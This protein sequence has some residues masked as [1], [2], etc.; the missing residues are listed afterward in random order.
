M[1][2]GPQDRPGAGPLAGRRIVVTRPVEQAMSLIRSLE[3]LGAEVVQLP[4]IAVA[5]VR[6]LAPLDRALRRL[7]SF[8]WVV[9]GS[10]N[11]VRVTFARYA[12][13]GLDPEVW[14]RIRVAAVGE[15]TAQAIRERGA[16]VN[17]VPDRTE[18]T[19]VVE[20]LGKLGVTGKAI[21]IPQ[22]REGRPELEKGLQ[23]HG[24]EVARVDVYESRI[25]WP[26]QSAVQELAR[27]G[28]DGTTFTSPSTVRNFAR[29]AESA[30]VDAQAAP[31][32]CIGEV[33]AGEARALGFRVAAVAKRASADELAEAVAAYFEGLPRRGREA[34]RSGSQ[35]SDA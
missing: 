27:R 9:F 7:E 20:E 26:P 32:F 1:G 22:A 16:P 6:D 5:P 8:D 31:A 34:Q 29:V 15:A 14:T 3:R 33:T 12:E 18:A 23:R 25:H 13:L 17:L 24:A 10:A 21:L 11:A 19:G 30:G 4:V 28:W 2:D 35:K